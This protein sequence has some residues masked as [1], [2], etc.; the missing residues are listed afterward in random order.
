MAA[1]SLGRVQSPEELVRAGFE[2]SPVVIVNECHDGL[3]HCARTR[4]VGLRIL[5]C[6]HAAGVRVLA[7]E[8]LTKDIAEQANKMRRLPEVTHPYLG[9]PDMSL[10]V[11]GALELGWDLLA[12]EC[13]FREKSGWAPGHARSLEFAN[14]RDQEQARH[15][16]EHL[17]ATSP[18]PPLLVWCGHSHQRKTPQ[19]WQ[20]G[21]TWAR[22]GQRMA[23]QGFEPFVVDQSVTVEYRPG[24]S[25][26]RDDLEQLRA[27][28][29]ALGGTG[30]FLREEDPNPVWREDHSADAYLLSVHNT[31]E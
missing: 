30:G 13:D 12:Y 31:M 29:E 2:R 8:A 28:L 23:E 14:W 7:V 1:A 24:V 6:A 9:Q 11:L 16:V 25:A 27:G 26:R 19:A 21:G 17:S 22:M 5:P 4:E 18:A 3:K 15:L 20:G 10:L